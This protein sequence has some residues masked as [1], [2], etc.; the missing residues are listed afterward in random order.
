MWPMGRHPRARRGRIVKQ[1]PDQ[2]GPITG[3][4]RVYGDWVRAH[5]I[6]FLLLGVAWTAFYWKVFRFEEDWGAVV[7]SALAAATTVTA[8]WGLGAIV[9]SCSAL[10]PPR[11]IKL[12]WIVVGVVWTIL[13][14]LVAEL[15]SDVRSMPRFH[16]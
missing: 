6:G 4:V 16:G 1:P 14:V 12:W 8:P 15:V 7:V 10:F 11:G 13:F 9:K 5:P 3:L 2:E